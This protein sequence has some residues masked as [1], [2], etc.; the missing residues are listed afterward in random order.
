MAAATSAREESMVRDLVQ[1]LLQGGGIDN[2]ERV[3][4]LLKKALAG[5][6]ETRSAIQTKNK[7]PPGLVAVVTKCPHRFKAVHMGRFNM[8]VAAGNLRPV[9]GPT[10]VI[11]DPSK[12]PSKRK[13]CLPAG[14]S[15]SAELSAAAQKQIVSSLVSAIASDPSREISLRCQ[16]IKDVDACYDTGSFDENG[17]RKE[18]STPRVGP[19]HD[20][21]DAAIAAR[22]HAKKTTSPALTAADATAWDNVVLAMQ[23]VYSARKTMGSQAVCKF[24]ASGC[25]SRALIDGVVGANEPKEREN[26]AKAAAFAALTA[27]ADGATAADTAAVAAFAAAAGTSNLTAWKAYAMQQTTEFA[28]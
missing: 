22:A 3:T 4:Q 18:A 24:F 16:K 17:V 20:M 25:F 7:P 19:A 21:W 6:H 14:V 5:Q 28:T 13:L 10:L 26:K 2:A 27:A 9:I 1:T 15:V 23:K 8:A 11:D 12:D